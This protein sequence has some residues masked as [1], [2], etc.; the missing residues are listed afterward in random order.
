MAG[1]SAQ[2]GIEGDDAC[3][4]AQGVGPFGGDL[5]L[6]E[7]ATAALPPG[8]EVGGESEGEGVVEGPGGGMIGCCR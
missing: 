5:G 8:L 3:A 1:S 2:N 6:G 7:L 4:C